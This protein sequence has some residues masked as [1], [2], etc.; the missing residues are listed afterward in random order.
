MSNKTSYTPEMVERMAETY[1]PEATEADRKA[2]VETL[3]EEFGKSTKSVIAKLV[4][5]KLYRKAERTTKAGKPVVKKD[6]LADRIGEALGLTEADVTSLTKANK[7]ALEAIA[8]F[9]EN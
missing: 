9:V 2:A 7:T 3:A 6:A 5:M 4:L 8:N 1:N